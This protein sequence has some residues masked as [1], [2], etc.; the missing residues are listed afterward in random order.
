MVSIDL[1]GEGPVQGSW[2]DVWTMASTLNIACTYW[3]TSDPSSAV[4]G[5]YNNGG[6]RNGL[7]LTM[8]RAGRVGNESGETAT[9]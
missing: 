3:R 6:Q 4:T 8:G 2:P 5:G 1:N 7:T 9:D